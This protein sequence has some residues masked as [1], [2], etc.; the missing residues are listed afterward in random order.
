MVWDAPLSVAPR[1]S[2]INHTVRNPT[3]Q[4]AAADRDPEKVLTVVGGQT[5]LTFKK[6]RRK[7]AVLYLSTAT[8]K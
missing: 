3:E 5:G 6:E 1:L 4:E 7:V 2:W 8:G